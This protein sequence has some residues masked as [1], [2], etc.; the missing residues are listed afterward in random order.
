[1]DQGHSNNHRYREEFSL[2]T[3]NDA[4]TEVNQE[5]PDA[6]LNEDAGGADEIADGGAAPG[7]TDAG[8]ALEDGKE[9]PA[10]VEEYVPN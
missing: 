2:E 8:A 10:A 5:T 4:N 3:P 9:K 7:E 1:M 6:V